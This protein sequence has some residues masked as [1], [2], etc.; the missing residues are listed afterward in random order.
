MSFWDDLGRLFEAAD[1]GLRGYADHDDLLRRRKIQEQNLE[2]DLAY[3]RALEADREEDNRRLRADY[4]AGLEA[5]GFV[6]DPKSTFRDSYTGRR[7]R[8]D[9]ARSPQGQAAKF[10]QDSESDEASRISGLITE[11]Q[12]GDPVRA[13]RAVASLLGQGA[14]AH[15]PPEL[16]RKV[17]GVTKEVD[18]VTAATRA[19]L[20]EQRRALAEERKLKG[21]E[22]LFNDAL[23]L[24]RSGATSPD[25]PA[26]GLEPARFHAGS[27]A[28]LASRSPALQRR[29]A[30]LGMT[31]DDWT[32]LN[33]RAIGQGAESARVAGARR[34]LSSRSGTR[35]LLEGLL[36]EGDSSTTPAPTVTAKPPAPTST[37]STT[38]A[39]PTVSADEA[40][41]EAEKE[42]ERAALRESYKVRMREL[43]RRQ[44]G[45]RTDTA[46]LKSILRSEFGARAA[47]L[48]I[49]LDDE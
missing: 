17:F 1:V 28:Y 8:F 29:A 38:P 13:Q 7:G 33:A 23:A 5:K 45:L 44:P 31:M 49:P 48:G 25:V 30:A 24:A 32:A 43:M 22:E 35:E 46:S 9:W 15:L 16:M 14:G 19:L 2:S 36:Q 6:D 20:L 10:R 37:T 27:L 47:R 4:I 41:K 3:R 40:E 39:Q 12:S 18:P 42:A 26:K 11:A 21:K 34:E